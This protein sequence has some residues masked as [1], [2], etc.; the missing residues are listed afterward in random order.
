MKRLLVA[1]TCMA[2]VLGGCSSVGKKNVAARKAPVRVAAAPAQ[3]APALDAKGE[4]IAHV[5]FRPGISSVTVENMAKKRG[6][7]GGVG[8]GLM[9]PPG[10]VEVYRMVCD[11][12]TVYEARCEL[13]QCKAI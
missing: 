2:V 5:P 1:V 3:Q 10:P 6:C 11:N 8:A 12:R 7:T 9:T 13:R 4:P